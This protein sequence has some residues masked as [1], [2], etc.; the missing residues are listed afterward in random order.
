MERE[1]YIEFEVKGDDLPYVIQSKWFNKPQYALEWMKENL[2]HIDD[3]KMNVYIMMK[4]DFDDIE[5]FCKVVNYQMI[6]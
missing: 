5:Q 3:D 1:Y 2:P 6:F 4:N